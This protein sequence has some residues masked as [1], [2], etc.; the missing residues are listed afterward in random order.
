MIMPLKRSS[1]HLSR[2]LIEIKRAALQTEDEAVR[3]KLWRW[4]YRL[5]HA[6]DEVRAM[7]MDAE[8]RRLL[9]FVFPD[10]LPA[11]FQDDNKPHSAKKDAIDSLADDDIPPRQ[12]GLWDE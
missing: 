10:G 12:K 2:V 1:V 6:Q 11:P 7:V 4:Y 3:Q 9:D 5:L 8:M